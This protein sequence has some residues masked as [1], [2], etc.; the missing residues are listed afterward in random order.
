MLDTPRPDE[1]KHFTDRGPCVLVLV[2]QAKGSTPRIAGTQML[3]STRDVLGTIGG[4]Q[5]EYMAI[6]AAR[7]LLIDKAKASDKES[8]LSIPLGP[9]IGQCCGGHVTLLLSK[10]TDAIAT[11]LTSNAKTAKE[12]QPS[13]YVFGAGHVG[14]SLAHALLPLPVNSLLIDNR[15][16]ELARA[17]SAIDQDLTPLPEHHI[18]TAPAGSAFVVLTHDH[19][20]DFL[21]TREALR[22]QH[23]AGDVAYIGMIGSKTK[24]ATFASWLATEEKET[25]PVERLSLDALTMPIGASTLRDK[26]PAV[27]AAMVAAEVMEAVGTFAPAHTAAQVPA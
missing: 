25:Q 26:R 23:S 1:I 5:L 24:R 20:L 4:G 18:R 16:D 11:N 19:A 27:I 7:A 17:G 14:R 6:D 12:F 21:L 9:E 15:E 8:R 22:R 3:V 2:E 13:V 10:V